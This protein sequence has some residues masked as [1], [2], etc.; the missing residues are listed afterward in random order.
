MN[1]FARRVIFAL[2]SFAL[3]P[4]FAGV[5]VQH[6]FTTPV[7]GLNGDGAN[8]ETG[9][10]LSGGLLFGTTV[11]GGSQGAGAAFCLAPDAAGFNAFRA[12]TNAPDAGN[13]RGELAF[14]GTRLFGTTFGGGSNG[15]GTLFAGQTNGS[16]TIIR[17]FAALSPDNATNSG[18]AAPTGVLVLSGATVFGATSAGGA[19]GNGTIF[20]MNTNGS[21]FAVL[22]DFSALDCASGTNA[23]GATPAGGLVLSGSTLYGVTSA[24]GSAGNGTIFSV[25]TN[26]ANFTILHSFSA[27]DPINAT[28]ADGATPMAGLLLTNNTLFGTALAGGQG[29][30][31]TMF[32]LDTTG[33]ALSVLH[34][35]S[36]T[37]PL[38]GINSDGASSCA[39]PALAGSFLYGTAAA[40]GTG[41]NGTIFSVN[42]NGTQFRTLYSFSALDPATG[43]N[44]DGAV[45]TAGL[46][47]LANSLYGTTFS[48]GP[49]GVGVVFAFHVP[50]PPA[51]ITNVVLHPDRTVTL[52]FVG[53]P[54][55]LNV[56][57]SG[58]NLNPSVAWQNISTNIA[59]T[60]GAWQF[61][62]SN[63]TSTRFYRSYAP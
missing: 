15:V 31:G 45:P 40:G 63:T 17:G 35:F 56:V 14:S 44:A 42:T 8:P 38:S 28:N 52:S 43:T 13:P 49:G 62:D 50:Y 39:T 2:C 3:G 16:L 36:A 46:V 6:I 55:S 61:T 10:V 1:R 22:H 4:C 26:G 5:I 20:S 34:H 32:S 59:D 12:F 51:V 53:G 57:Q 9:L 21:G 48:G 24:G 11:N 23:D 30:N 19:A 29:G 18:G 41:A 54:G 27:M 7:A 58:A 37:A 25:G 47:L 60:Q 33:A